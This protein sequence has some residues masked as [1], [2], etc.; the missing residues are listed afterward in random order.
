M[1]RAGRASFL[2]A[3]TLIGLK[4]WAA[5]VSGSL[6]LVGTL[7]DSVLDLLVSLVSVAAIETAI[8]PPDL[9]HRFGHGKAEGV[10]GLIQAVVVSATAVGLAVTSL[11]NLVNPSPVLSGGV[12]IGVLIA[13]MLLT[14][15]LLSYQRRV[16]RLTGSMAVQADSMHYASDFAMNGGVLISIVLSTQLGWHYADPLAGLA[17]SAWVMHS[18][19]EIGRESLDMLLDREL[20]DDM[21]EKISAII[22]SHPEVKGIHDLRTR[23]SGS[24]PIF[25]FHLELDA[26]M[27]LRHAHVI[28]D[29]VEEL[30]HAEIEGAHVL[31]HLDPDDLIPDEPVLA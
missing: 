2:T 16:V 3:L 23:R 11:V 27:S 24:H 22:M 4:A 20:G 25:Q 31:I 7:V 1:R 14:W 6:A 18:A 29:E 12:A 10:A 5:W 9:Q 15:A 19:M 21:R 28:S 13:S 8:R 26:E 17:V 30:L